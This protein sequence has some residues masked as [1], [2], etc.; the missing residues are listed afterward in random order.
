MKTQY[1]VLMEDPE[2][3]RLYVIEGL[4][5][6]AS[7]TIA[8][9]MAE[10]NVTKAELAKRLKKSRSWVTQML[11]GKANLTVRTLAEAAFA[12]GAEL[13]LD[14]Q[15]Q[16]RRKAAD[17]DAAPRR[18]ALSRRVNRGKAIRNQSIQ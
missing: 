7:E 4:V 10:Q 18:R 17:V 14:A 5:A 6:D 12:L 2:F 15:R 1:Q 13:K 3:R 8:R 11:S 16:N 9:L